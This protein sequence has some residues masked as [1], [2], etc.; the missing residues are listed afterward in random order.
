[1][2]MQELVVK[3]R[4]YRR[5]DESVAVSIKTLEELVNLARL[6]A[7]GANSQPLKYILSADVETNHLVFPALGW[8]AYLKDWPGPQEGERPSAY[9]ILLGDT[10]IKKN[11]G[12]DPG[13]AA[14]TIMLGAT[15]V[16]LGG[17][18]IASFN[19]TMLVENLKIPER[20]DVL[21]VLALGKPIETVRVEVMDAAG[22]VRYWRSEDQVHHVPKRS[23]EDVI[24]NRVGPVP[25]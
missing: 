2:K 21:L 25:S 23:L 5:F 22:D 11:F 17:C 12:I 15:D 1:M 9:I 20:Y 6:S 4:S 18:M 14:Q 7:S 16:G 19:K 24:L 10:E 8:A 3:T 13:I